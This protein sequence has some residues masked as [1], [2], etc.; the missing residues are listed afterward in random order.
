MFKI[1]NYSFNGTIEDVIL[2]MRSE[3][4][5]NGIN[6]FHDIKVRDKYITVTCPYHKNGNESKPSAGFRVDNG[7]FSC[8]TCSEKHSLTEVIAHCYGI[9]EYD[10]LEWLKENF[11]FD[12]FE[13]SV[14]LDLF[15]KKEK[16]KI[17]YI[18]N[19]ELQKYRVFHPYMFQRKMTKDI[20]R[21]YDIGYDKAT[22]CIIFP[23]KDEFGNILFLAKR[24]VKTKF[25]NYPKDVD[26]PVYGLYELNRDEPNAKMV[27]I[28][29]SMINCLTCRSWGYPA[30]A[31]NGTGS[32]EQLEKLARLQ[33]PT[34][35]LALDGDDAG[36]KGTRKIIKKLRNKKLIYVIEIPQGKDVNDLDKEEF[37]RLYENKLPLAAYEKKYAEVK[38]DKRNTSS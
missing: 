32:A 1:R 15:P 5:K 13:N 8:F 27:I 20:I 38:N 31:L 9:S 16:K 11:S 35:V 2:K 33:Y 7:Y 29:E 21:K 24:S 28:T 3:L 22:D 10:A 18:D 30:L 19:K 26:K 25:F 17:N 37:D 23:N 4:L 12:E 34:Y 6:Y 14:K 36:A